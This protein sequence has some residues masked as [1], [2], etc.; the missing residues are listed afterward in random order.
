M[1]TFLE[2]Y[3]PIINFDI[4]PE[5]DLK[6]LNE[7]LNI[8]LS[9]KDQRQLNLVRTFIDV[10]NLRSYLTAERLFAGG[11]VDSDEIGYCIENQ[12]EYPNFVFD[13]FSKYTDI[14]DRIHHFREL[15]LSLYDWLMEQTC[16][17]LH[18]FFEYDRKLWITS[19][20]YF[21]KK[22]GRNLRED[23]D[24]LDIHD[25]VTRL[26]IQ[27]H[28]SEH[29]EFPEGLEG[30]DLELDVAY[31]DPLKEIEM[32]AR[33][34][35]NFCQ[36]AILNNPFSIDSILAYYLQVFALCDF[37]ESQDE[38]LTKKGGDILLKRIQEIR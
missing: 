13:Y 23:L 17:F 38:N 11:L 7:L 35:F 1:Y 26:L 8:H 29:F 32:I 27:Q 16:C 33:L 28:E 6:D 2:C 25:D 20:A 31:K 12:I 15:I 21:A 10:L 3:F 14:N 34:R 30:I 36:T 18:D 5:L 4:K 37:Y 22:R 9:I 19:Y 24:F